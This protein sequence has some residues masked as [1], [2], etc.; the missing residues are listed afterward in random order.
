MLVPEHDASEIANAILQVLEN[1]KNFSPDK[2]VEAVKN[3]S[4]DIILGNI[5]KIYRDLA[6]A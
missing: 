5:Y 1:K 3:Y 6:E 2:C 4:M